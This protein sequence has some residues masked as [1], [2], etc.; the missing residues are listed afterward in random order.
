[1]PMAVMISVPTIFIQVSGPPD[2]SSNATMWSGGDPPIVGTQLPAQ[3][4]TQ[5]GHCSSRV[6][7]WGRGSVMTPPLMVSASHNYPKYNVQYIMVSQISYQNT[8][9]NPLYY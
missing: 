9:N 2:S 5:T 8:R 6:R 1:M 7:P 3:G 4:N